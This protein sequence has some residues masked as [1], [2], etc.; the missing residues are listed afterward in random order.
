VGQAGAVLL[1]VEL[2]LL[3]HS[4]GNGGLPP[5]LTATSAG[6]SYPQLVTVTFEAANVRNALHTAKRAL[7]YYRWFLRNRAQPIRD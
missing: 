3:F 6:P 5:T 4:R 7:D 1:A 2:A